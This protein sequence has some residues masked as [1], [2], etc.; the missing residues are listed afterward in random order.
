[1]VD[2]IVTCDQPFKEV[3]RLAF[4]HLLEYTHLQPSLHIPGCHTIKQ[5]I[6]KMSQDTIDGT[7]SMLLVHHV[8]SD[9]L[10]SLTINCIG[11]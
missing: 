6:M 1:M 4:C 3:E 9:S 10:T 2:W 11:A 8:C 5:Q 7:R